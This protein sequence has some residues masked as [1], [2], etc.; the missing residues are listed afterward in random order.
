MSSFSIG[1]VARMCGL[2][3]STIRYYEKA[4]LVPKPMRV[5]R[6]RRYTAEGI[7]RL[8]LVRVAREAGF[9][10][11]E[12]RTFVSGFSEST[13]PAIRWRMLAERKLVE[14]GQQMARLKRMKRLLD[15]SFQCEC[16]SIEDCARIIGKARPAAAAGTASAIA[17]ARRTR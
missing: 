5:S 2:R 12:T 9:T 1:E 3:P 11:A 16:P 8:H 15:S 6:Q 10:I 7:G 14:I 13:P 17:C 4:G